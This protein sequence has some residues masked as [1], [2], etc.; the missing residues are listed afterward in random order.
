VTDKRNFIFAILVFVAPIVVAW[1]GLS[2]A[3]AAGLV[4]LLLLGRWV[5]AFPRAV[6]YVDSLYQGR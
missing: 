3:A 1:Y 4:V 2:V 5:D 6:S